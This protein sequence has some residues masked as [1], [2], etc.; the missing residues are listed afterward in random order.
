MRS[1]GIFVLSAMLAGAASAQM[2]DHS[3]HQGA[4][5]KSE[6][7]AHKGTGVVKSLDAEKGT[8]MLAHDP[9][10]SLRWPAMTMKFTARD[11]KLLDKLAPG[12][13][14]EFEFVVEGKDYILTR[15][16]QGAPAR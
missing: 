7:K 3:G 13:K 5:A 16:K 1:L 12:R 2:K 14:V 15:L 6:A 10:P 8:V 9:I 4:A 11:K